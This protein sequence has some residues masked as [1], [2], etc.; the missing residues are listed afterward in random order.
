M[1]HII[2]LFAIVA[3]LGV[4]ADGYVTLTANSNTSKGFANAS[5]SEMVDDPSTRDYL[6]AGGYTFYTTQNETINAHSLTLGIVG[7]TECIFFAYYSATFKNEGVIF[8]N[9][10]VYPRA[11]P[12]TFSGKAT[13]TSPSTAPFRFHGTNYR[14]VGFTIAGDAHSAETA[15]I[16]AYSQGT[17]GFYVTFKGDTRD[18]LGS[19]VITSQYDRTGAP[20]G[21]E[22][23]LTDSASY[24]GG[25]ITVRDGATFSPQIA[26]SV[27]SLSLEPGSSLS[28]VAGSTLAI[29]TAFTVTGGPV[30]I[31]LSG[32][33]S[34]AVASVTRYALI[35]M[36]S[37][38]VCTT[39]DFSVKNAGASYT[40]AADLFMEDN[41]ETKTLYAEYYPVVALKTKN[42]STTSN[43]TASSAV[44]NGAYWADEL[45]V[46]GAA[47]YTV[48]KISGT[49][50]LT[51]PYSESAATFP[52]RSLLFNNTTAFYVHALDYTITNLHFTTGNDPGTT[53]FSL[54]GTNVT[55]R[56]TFRVTG[57]V[58]FAP[59]KSGSIKLVGPISGTS[60][61]VLSV[62]GASASTSAS[63]GIV[64]LDCDASDYAGKYLV[65]L[66]YPSNGSFGAQFTSLRVYS[67]AALGGPRPSFAYDALRLDTM[68][69]LEAFDSFTLDEP[70][71]GVFVSGQGRFYVASDKTLTLKEQLTVNGRF[72]KE[73]SGTLGLGGALRFLDGEGALTETAPADAMNRTFY[74]T[75]GT[76]KPLAARSLDGLDVVFSNVTSKANVALRFDAAPEEV[77]MGQYGVVNLKGDAPL[78]A[79]TTS[80]SVPVEFDLPAETTEE[81]FSVPL[82]TVAEDRAAT[83]AGLLALPRKVVAGDRKYVVSVETE[84]VTVDE[85]AATTISAKF[86]AIPRGTRI[87]I[88]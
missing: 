53:L 43:V 45:P 51:L 38:S 64:V 12:D 14:P 11:S 72:Y 55:L 57:L 49:T 16:L 87:S 78:T 73:G 71:R 39:A 15:G 61:G 42:S 7:G 59:R 77:E 34:S 66:E 52:G 35:T 3:C 19:V 5:W 27:G 76:L 88:R 10:E 60:S 50:G 80:G 86:R 69:R 21:A 6:A 20:W 84:S 29:R 41:G 81:T 8:A 70:T 18:Y 37:S 56:S 32:A 17:N 25:S 62:F 24:F 83:V 9:G 26:T 22:L 28:L 65:T 30:P 75:A 36:P 63:R 1:K 67:A 79:V 58:K 82:F 40:T 23:R 68:G 54:D 13:F 47:H 4:R 33:P 74:V 44:T 46:H 31:T 2:I 48:S 85:V